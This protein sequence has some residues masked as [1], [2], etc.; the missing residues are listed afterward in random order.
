[1]GVANIDATRRRLRKLAEL[2]ADRVQ[3]LMRTFTLAGMAG[4]IDQTPRDTGRLVSGWDVT[5]GSPS[6]RIEPARSEGNPDTRDGGTIAFEKAAEV[7]PNIPAFTIVH[8]TN[9]TP[10]AEVIE[11]GLFDPPNPG[12]SKDPRPGRK[13][14]ELVVGGFSTQAPAGMLRNALLRIATA[15]REASGALQQ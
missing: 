14:Q 7:L 15:T 13:G 10:Y 1:M 5:I 12:P 4:A 9:N 2:P 6:S 11:L 3:A 8:V